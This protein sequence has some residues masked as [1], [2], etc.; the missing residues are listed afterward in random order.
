MLQCRLYNSSYHVHFHYIDGNQ[1]VVIDTP[2][3]TSTRI[4]TEPFS[5]IGPNIMLSQ[6]GVKSPPPR[7]DSC[8][9]PALPSYFTDACV[10]NPEVLPTMV[11]QALMDA[12]IQ[13]LLGWIATNPYSELKRHSAVMNTALLNTQELSFLRTRSGAYTKEKQDTTLQKAVLFSS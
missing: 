5:L 7:Y 12:F 11:Y 8:E 13:N 1:T 6:E 9:D 10:S 2:R 4:T 3:E